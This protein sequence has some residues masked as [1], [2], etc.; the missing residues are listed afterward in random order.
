MSTHDQIAQFNDLPED[1]W[2]VEASDFLKSRQSL[3]MVMAESSVNRFG[4][5]DHVKYDVLQEY[6]WTGLDLLTAERDNPGAISEI[7]ATWEAILRR[8]GSGRVRTLLERERGGYGT[9][10]VARQ[11]KTRFL[12]QRRTELVTQLRREPTPTELVEYANL[13]AGLMRKDAARQSLHFTTDD[14]SHMSGAMETSLEENA[15][16][17]TVADQVSGHFG[18]DFV[19]HP[20][21][22]PEFVK[23]VIDECE[24]V[25]RMCALV[26][27]SWFGQFLDG[28]D[29][30][31]V[32]DTDEVAAAM[33]ITPR[34][35]N[36]QQARIRQV[37]VGVF[38]EMF[39]NTD[40]D[41]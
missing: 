37:A 24:K 40:P 10:A 6:M 25:S 19:V 31:R 39:P 13:K 15:V 32:L 2:R 4:V 29:T 1:Q 14:V 21:E 5:R 8:R 22:S 27:R 35:V 18:D 3:M 38:N 26:A 36:S 7:G 11:R 34:S 23:R 16:A 9:G 41:A 30:R 33:G 20:Y 28:S 12:G 17:D